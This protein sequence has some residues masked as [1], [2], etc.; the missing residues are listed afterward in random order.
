MDLRIFR[1]LTL[2]GIKELKVVFGSLGVFCV[3][4]LGI[5][6]CEVKKRKDLRGIWFG[7]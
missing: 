6:K 4:H 5:V 7:T 1:N 2:N 3:F